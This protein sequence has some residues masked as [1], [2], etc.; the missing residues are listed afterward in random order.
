[1]K[2]YI[3]ASTKPWNLDAFIAR[4][5]TLPGEWLC[6]T[7][8]HDLTESLI[9]SMKP[10]YV[11]FPHWSAKVPDGIL[12][13]AECVCFHMTDVPFGRGGSPLQNLIVR[14]IAETKLTALRMTADL[15]AGPVYAKV[16]LQL[17]GSAG[18]IF[19]R[20]AKA[21]L[22]LVAQIVAE[23]PTPV[24]QRGEATLFKRRRP[25]ESAL[26]DSGDSE[27][28]YDHIRMLDADTYPR[29]FLDHGSFRLTFSDAVR[30]GTEVV[31]R[32]RIAPRSGE[33]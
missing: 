2:R 32:V 25:A 24:P 1:M 11:F 26:P 9:A 27:S 12:N 20:A 19:E 28:L 10:R 31:A 14:G 4:R 8:A 13:A 6:V 23:E 17:D 18:E 5:P 3:F 30:D 15:D 22:D 21:V 33:K 16:P 7:D 29:A